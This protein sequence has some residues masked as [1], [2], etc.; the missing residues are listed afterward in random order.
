MAKNSKS[1][2]EEYHSR[3]NSQDKLIKKNNFTYILLLETMEKY[4]DK[5]MNVLD[6]GCGAGTLDFYLSDKVKK[7]KGIDISKKAISSCEITKN[8][9]GIKNL[10]FELI[11]FPKEKPKGK[12]D[13][14]I[15]SEVIE[16]LEDDN[17]SIK[18]IYKLL[19]PGGILFLSTPSVNAPLHK[20]GLTKKFDKDVG[21]VRRYNLTELSKLLTT[22][23]FKILET[24]KI[25][26]ILR[27]FLFVNPIAGKL[28]RFIKFSLSDIVTTADSATVPIFGESNYI[29]VAKKI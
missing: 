5:K 8:N 22:N 14:I 16:H 15:F 29:V 6:I 7:I 2:H 20:L 13:F 26:G 10:D 4:L 3:T 24:K 12:Y 28:V 27:N 23:K 19:K 18:E 11:Y 17:L 21:H 1:I 9:L 25:E